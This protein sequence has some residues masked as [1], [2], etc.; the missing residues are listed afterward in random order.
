[1]SRHAQVT[2]GWA[3]GEYTFR[4]G[5]GELMT[6]QEA[7]DAGPAHILERLQTDRWRVQDVEQTLFLGLLGGGMERAPARTLIRAYVHERPL[8]ENVLVAQSIILAAL[9][10]APDDDEL[11][12]LPGKPVPADPIQSH[13]SP[14]E[15]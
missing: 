8:A 15:S 4:L 9:V 14:G 11:E 12:D 1:M 7:C 10:G 6:L 3:D 2:L 13:P 5:L